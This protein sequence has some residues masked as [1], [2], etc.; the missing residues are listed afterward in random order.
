MTNWI[1]V[2]D[3]LPEDDQTVLMCEVGQSGLPLIGWYEVELSDIAGFYMAHTFQNARVH[4][5]HW[6][7]IPE[8]PK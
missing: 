6:L 2:N 7:P 3:R 5:T 8:R 1:S 4:I